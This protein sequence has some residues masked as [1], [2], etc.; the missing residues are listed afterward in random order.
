MSATTDAS[1]LRTRQREPQRRL[2]L[3]GGTN[4]APG[5]I[6]VVVADRQ[7]L[8]RAGIR[9]LL[10]REAGIVVIG[11]AETG[12]EA[13][14]LVRRT[15]PDV[16]VLDAR[17]AALDLVRSTQEILR[18]PA[19][20]VMLVA[21]GEDDARI[22]AALRAGARGVLLDDAQPD[23]LVHAVRVLA[24]GATA[25]PAT[26]ASDLVSADLDRAADV[27]PMPWTSR[28]R[29]SH[30]EQHMLT[31]RLTEILRGCAHGTL[32][33]LPRTSPVSLVPAG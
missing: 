4:C 5:T 16:V 24:R 26:L 29:R 6:R 30:K 12:E 20:A 27:I 2:R 13:I 1:T 9:V 28:R 17:G 23:E 15:R 11:E 14:G 31:P 8:T 10:E 32:V 22:L 25:L 33:Q 18:Q 7:A 3:V 19:I 21:R